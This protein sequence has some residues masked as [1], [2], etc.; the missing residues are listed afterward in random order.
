MNFYS[1]SETACRY[2][3]RVFTYL[4]STIHHHVN[5]ISSIRDHCVV[6]DA[7]ILIHNQAEFR[8]SDPKAGDVANDHLLNEF[9]SVLSMPTNL[10]HV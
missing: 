10:S 5:V 6:N 7:S 3:R 8:F 9:D 4:T 2:L 1:T